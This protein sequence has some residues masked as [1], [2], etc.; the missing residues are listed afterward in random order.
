MTDDD[1]ADLIE[2]KDSLLQTFETFETSFEALQSKVV[3]T[4]SIIVVESTETE[5][6]VKIL[7]DKIHKAEN[8]LKEASEK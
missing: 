5:T 3:E 7:V 4:I 8:L 2:T 1:Q 6:F